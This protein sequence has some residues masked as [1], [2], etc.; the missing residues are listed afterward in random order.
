MKLIHISDLH[1]GKKVN[2]FSMLEEQRF[3]LEQ[4]INTAVAENPFGVMISGDV[5]DKSVPSAEAVQV[6][7]DFL[8]KLSEMNLKVF[9]ISGNHD[10]PE[11]LAFAGRIMNKN[12]IYISPVY[13]GR[14]EPLTFNDEYGNI[15]FYLLPYL[16]PSFV[17]RFYP[18]N[19]ID[20]YTDALKTVIDDMHINTAERNVIIAHQFVTGAGTSGSEEIFVGGS[21]NVACEVFADFDYAALGHIHR[22][23]NVCGTSVRYCGTPLKYSL[24]EINHKKTVTVVELNQKGSV[25]ISERALTPIHD[26]REIKG[27]YDTL[28]SKKFYSDIDTNDYM[29][30]ILTD[31]S[32]IPE[33][34]GRLR[35]VY[36]NIMK[37]SY[38]NTKTRS[39]GGGIFDD[40]E[41]IKTPIEFLAEFYK[42]QN[43]LE[44]DEDKY[45]Y[46]KNVIDCVSEVCI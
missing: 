15:N 18:E 23:Q 38:D 4:I 2:E 31:E 8:V 1:I 24:S 6:F 33:A 20:S 40:C 11:R 41:K 32:E 28:V 26:M 21:E 36:P 30:V 3:V 46:V 27:T 29:N 25:S 42:K 13:G 5:Y 10:S 34:L 12:G 39:G 17:R 9:V 7:D 44:L 14:V 22:P 37:L 43:G 16:K 45:N 35:S 19:E